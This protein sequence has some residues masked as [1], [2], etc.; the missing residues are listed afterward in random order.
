M[1][2]CARPFILKLAQ[3]ADKL[4][5]TEFVLITD[6]TMAFDQAVSLNIPNADLKIACVKSKG[7]L[8]SSLNSALAYCE[9]DYI[10]RIDDDEALS[11]A[12][13][14]WLINNCWL[15]QDH[16]EFPRAHMWDHC[17]SVLM[18]PQLFPDYQTRLSIKAKSGD[19]F[20]VHAGSPFG[21]GERAPVTIEHHKFVIKDYETRSAIAAVYDNYSPGYG[22]GNM[23]PF[24]LPEDAYKGHMVKLVAPWDGGIPWT[25]DWEALQQW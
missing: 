17:K 18:T 25:P 10:L 15:E 13:E 7:Y 1:E 12:M 19:R 4:E 2:W 9:G 21:G 6:G 3:L 24:S 8:E 5:S 14:K 11:P 16:W 22:T 20:G 23:K